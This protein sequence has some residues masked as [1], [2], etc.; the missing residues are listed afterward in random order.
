MPR[1]ARTDAPGA[2]Y[3][4]ICRGIERRNIFRD[5][6]DRSRFPERLGS[7]LQETSTSCLGWALTPNHSHLLLKTGNMP[8]AQ[9]MHR[10]LTGYVLTFHRCG[11][12]FQDHYESILCREDTYLPGPV[13]YI[14]LNPIR[15]GIVKALKVA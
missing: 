3:R 7:L 10:L 14:H 2:F 1:Q 13:R 9:L 8:V 15:A 6:T 4:I 11:R 5:N 12:L